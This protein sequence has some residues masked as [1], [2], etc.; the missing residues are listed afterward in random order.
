MH[1]VIMAGGA[2][3][4]FWPLSRRHRPK[5]L[6]SLF[7]ETPMITQTVARFEG[8]VPVD[9][10]WIVTNDA[11]GDAI[12]EAVPGVPRENILTEPVARNTAPCI[13]LAAAAIRARTGRGDEVMAVFPADHF[14]RDRAAF[15]AAVAHA[16][17]EAESGAIVTLGIEPT[18][19]ETGYGYIR[20]GDALEDGVMTAD[21]FVEKPDAETA[22]AYL[23]DGHYLWNSGMFA[24]RVDA[25]LDELDRQ[26]PTLGA[27][28]RAM[29]PLLAAGDDAALTALFEEIQPV[30]IDYGVMEG[31]RNVRVVPV[32]FGWSDVGH[33]DALPQVADTDDSG[34]VLMGDVVAVDCRESVLMGNDARVLAAV[35]LDRLVVVDT[36]DAVLVA[37]RD[38]VQEVRAIVEALKGRDGGIV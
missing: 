1:V 21:A 24:F 13:G 12:A 32:R 37:P 9:H 18:K 22:L 34:N 36:V 27:Q 2:G 23:T 15:Q 29:E 3:T 5:Q 26:L 6:L 4:R 28:V 7:G 20:C 25:I 19:P 35:G 30:S 14:I 17:R 8:M 38:R 11:L 10:I 33:W 31:A 16:V